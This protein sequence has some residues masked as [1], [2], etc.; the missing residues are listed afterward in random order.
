MA[1]RL[2]SRLVDGL[3]A[4]GAAGKPSLDD[5]GQ[6]ERFCFGANLF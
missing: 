6:P 5:F 2:K 1:E 4:K 3:N